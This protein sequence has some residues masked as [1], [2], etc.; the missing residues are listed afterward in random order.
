[1]WY[2]P[3][4]KKNRSS[5]LVKVKDKRASRSVPPSEQW[6]A[7]TPSHGDA[8]RAW[9]AF[10]I[11]QPCGW[12]VYLYYDSVAINGRTR[13]KR[14]LVR[15]LADGGGRAEGK[16]IALGII[17]IVSVMGVMVRQVQRNEVLF[18]CLCRCHQAER[19]FTLNV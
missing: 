9:R 17:G 7:V 19:K 11:S 1:M 13:Y 10:P 3:A 6:G 4:E 2:V 16:S 12:L 18:R 8:N 14:T 5:R 15:I